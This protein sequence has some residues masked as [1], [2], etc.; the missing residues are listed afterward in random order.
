MIVAALRSRPANER[1]LTSGY[2]GGAIAWDSELSL[3]TTKTSQI[4]RK[5]LIKGYGN[6]H[7][8]S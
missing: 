6:D 7:L 5:H 2:V 4:A 8:A 1:L 3:M